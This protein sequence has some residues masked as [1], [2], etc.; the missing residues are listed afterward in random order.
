[1]S[2]ADSEERGDDMATTDLR[3]RRDNPLSFSHS[4]GARCGPRWARRSHAEAPFSPS[5]PPLLD[6]P[7][8]RGS[9]R[10]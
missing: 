10:R 8:D 9:G 1:V 7:G 6:S 4:P 2:T 5:L 3:G